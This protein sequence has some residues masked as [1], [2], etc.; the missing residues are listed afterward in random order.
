MPKFHLKRSAVLAGLVGIAV[1]GA[2]V[3]P[4]AASAH[5][6]NPPKGSA[7]GKLVL[8]PATGNANTSPTWSTT[9]ACPADH[10]AGA[11]LVGYDNAGIGQQF[12]DT[13]SP[14]NGN[15]TPKPVLAPMG[16]LVG[17]LGAIPDTYEFTVICVASLTDTVPVQSTFVTFAADGS[18][19]TSATPP[20]GAVST[21]TNV[22]TSTNAVGNGGMVTFPATVAP[23]TAVGKVEFLDGATSIGLVNL[24]NGSAQLQA[25]LTGLGQ[26]TVTAKFEPTDVNAFT[27]SQGTV[28]VTVTGGN[29]QSETIN[30]NVPQ[31]EGPFILT[32]SSNP[33][34]LSTAALSADFTHFSAS[35]T[36]SDVTV[37]DERNQTQ[38][39]W[40][41]S[42]QIGNFSDGTHTIPGNSLGWT[43]AVK[44]QNPAADVVAGPV[45]AAGSTPGLS[46]SSLLAS[47]A[48]NKGLHTTVL[49]AA[50]DF[51]V[52]SSTKPGNYSATLTITAVPSAS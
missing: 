10:Q 23:T 47:A 2:L 49:N 30:V 13:F 48:V 6:S 42:G 4:V 21:T 39:G 26:H 36:L 17:Q 25:P 40:R 1:V 43:P 8:S 29:V 45:V 9:Q 12:S 19:T 31:S 28:S 50:L 44:T 3:M 51:E 46:A 16:A 15:I 18:W 41:V 14:G 7:P 37:S 5:V 27:G 32:V 38:P 52:P 34:S 24:V 22:T 35:G 11:F 20:A 33:V